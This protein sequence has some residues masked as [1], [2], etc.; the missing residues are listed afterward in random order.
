[1][2][3]SFFIRI[4]TL[5]MT[6]VTIVNI[7]SGRYSRNK[8]LVFR[9]ERVVVRLSIHDTEKIECLVPVAQGIAE[10]MEKKGF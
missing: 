9:K 1:V 8:F 7:F 10:Q 6:N 4:K 5:A 2:K 3:S